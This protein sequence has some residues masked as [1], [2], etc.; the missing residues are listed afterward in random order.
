MKVQDYSIIDRLRKTPAQISLLSLLI[1]SKEHACVLITILNEAHDSEKTTVNQLEK[2]ANKYFEVNRISFTDDELPDEGVGHNRAL[3]LL[4]KYEEHYVKRVMV[5]GGSSIDVCLLSTL[6]SMKINIDKIR[7]NNVRIRAFDGSTRDTIGEI[8]L[9]MTI[10]PVDLEI[11]FQGTVGLGFR[12]RKEDEDKVNNHK[13]H[14][15]VLRK[16]IP[17]IF[18]TFV[19]PRLQEG[20]N[21]S[22]QKNIDET[23]HGFSQIF[24]EVNMIQAGEG[25]SR[26]D[27]IVNDGFNNMTCMWNSRTDLKKLS[28]F[29]IIHHEVEY[30][31]DEGLSV[32]LVVHKLLAYP[33]FSLVQQKQRKFK[34]DMNDKIKEEIMKQLRANVVR[35][36]RYT[37]WVENIVHVPKKDGKTRVCIDYRDLNKAN[38]KDNIPL[39]NIRILVDNC[40]KHEIQSFVD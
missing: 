14:C 28:N 30:D 35:V 34:T 7:P 9:T 25:T 5:D 4:V 33:N 37:T 39:P 1:H 18:Y 24:S 15:W 38:P 2:M 17:H 23:C 27:I 12:P 26:D 11:I 8:S 21:S 36:V 40:A 31:E 29:E 32:D 13:K 19:K 22:A 6:Q 16:P 20:R 10:G 3:H